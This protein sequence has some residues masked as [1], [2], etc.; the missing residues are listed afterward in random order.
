MD[1][2]TFRSKSLSRKN[3]FQL[4]LRS[5]FIQGSFSTK[6]RQNVG[7]AFCMEPIGRFIWDDPEK[8]KHFFVRHM[9]FYNGNPFMITL[10]LGAVAKMEEMLY[11]NNEITENDIISFKKIV[12]PAT[13][14][15]GD[16]FFWSTF[17]PFGII[18]GLII[19]LLYGL[20][21]VLLFLFVFNIPTII[22]RWHWLKAGYRLG[23]KVINEIRNRRLE[24]TVQLMESIGAVSLAFL[25]VVYSGT[26]DFSTIWVI[27]ATAGLFIFSIIMFS[28]KFALSGV[29]SLCLCV[30][31]IWGML[32]YKII[33]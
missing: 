3:L 28:R 9:D 1:S 24:K 19:S 25:A 4:F 6:Y 30:A 7:F 26:S 32:I 29:F 27:G 12:G 23:P 18:L 13:G 10:V 15:V 33:Y 22:L 17:R 31:V 21:G 2:N 14:S 5:F 8:L 16:R 20:W 11:N